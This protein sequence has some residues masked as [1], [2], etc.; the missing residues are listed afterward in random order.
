M[1][2]PSKQVPDKAQSDALAPARQPKA[3]RL[4][5]ALVLIVVYWIGYAVVTNN[6]TISPLMQFMYSFWAPMVV[7]LLLIVWWLIFSRMAWL[8]RIWGIIWLAAGGLAASALSHNTIATPPVPIF[9]LV[10]AMPIA[11]TAVVVWLV[12]MRGAAT[13]PVRLGVVAASLLA[14]GYFT[15]LRVDGLDGEFAVERYWR[16]EPTE[17]SKYVA[18]LT[19]VSHQPGK[20]GAAPAASAAAKGVT[21][22]SGASGA[23]TL[24]TEAAPSDWPQFRGAARDSVLRGVSI[25]PDWKAHP[26]RELWRRRVGPGW[27]SFATIGEVAFTQEQRG[28]NEAVVCFDIPTGKEHWSYVEPARFEE[29]VAG[30]GPRA[31]PTFVSGRLFTQGASGKLN[32]LDAA[33]GEIIWSRD[34]RVDAALEALP[35]WGIS[36][37]PLVTHGAVITFAGG[38]DGKSVLAYDAATGEPKWQGGLGTHGYASPQLH[39]AGGVDQVLMVSD[40]G[41]QAFDPE[42]GKLLWEHPWLLQ[43]MYRVCQPHVTQDGK[44]AYGTPMM[45]G[46]KLLSLAKEGDAW[47]A[48]EVWTCKDLKPYFNDFVEHEGYLYGFDG[49]I[50]SC[51][52]LATGK[53]AWQKGRY[54]HGQ[55]L[56][57]ADQGLMLVVSEKGELVL[58]QASPKNL[59]ERAKIK[60][61]KGK[62]WNHPVLTGSKLLVRNDEEMACFELA[63]QETK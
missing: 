42:T 58:L 57:L 45:E 52:D 16:W 20:L 8:D 29:V 63:G 47:T 21:T 28:E 10:W 56:L 26:P 13:W 6:S 40:H 22:F 50:F 48:T 37:S 15:L 30:A 17:E 35:Q 23:V 27:S 18:E 44:I 54:G 49:P 38:K 61:L 51:I 2:T 41:L 33:T 34:I 39:T 5:P 36:S 3:P 62:T 14:F 4:W 55:V 31:T 32:C 12:V 19:T 53:K 59:V 7:A 1:T 25:D 60:A 9:L 46:T 24:P 43:G 11:M